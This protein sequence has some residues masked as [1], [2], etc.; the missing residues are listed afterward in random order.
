MGKHHVKG[1]YQVNMHP[2]VIRDC[3]EKHLFH[4]ENDGIYLK[5]KKGQKIKVYVGTDTE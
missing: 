4:Y 2:S 1:D 5:T 3:N